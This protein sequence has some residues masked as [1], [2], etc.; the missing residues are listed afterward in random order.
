[1]YPKTLEEAPIPNNDSK[2]GLVKA[3]SA[4]KDCE[5]S[6][7]TPKLSYISNIS[8]RAQIVLWMAS[9]QDL[10]CC[11]IVVASGLSWLSP[12]W[13]SWLVGL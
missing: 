12:T 11:C 6:P 2:Q 9:K 7:V 8:N 5:I 4:T 10:K 3:G 13:L 1:V